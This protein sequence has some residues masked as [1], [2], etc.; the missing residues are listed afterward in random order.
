MLGDF[1]YERRHHA[2]FRRRALDP[3]ARLRAVRLKLRQQMR[4][5]ASRLALEDDDPA[6]FAARERVG[7]AVQ[8]GCLGLA[9][10][11]REPRRRR[12]A[13]RGIGRVRVFFGWLR[14]VAIV[15]G[16]L[17]LLL[18][19]AP[20]LKSHLLRAQTAR[21][22]DRCALGALRQAECDGIGV[23]LDRD[24]IKGNKL[25]ARSIDVVM[26]AVGRATRALGLSGRKREHAVA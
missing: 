7:R 20:L 16:R 13:A 2:R 6:A 10:V 3:V 1:C 17:V 19:L 11:R 8:R 24:G 21:R 25:I 9:A 12:R 14:V 23:A 26:I 5:A 18:V 15:F 4:F 22:R